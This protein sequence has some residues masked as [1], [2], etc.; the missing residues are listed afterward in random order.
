[1]PRPKK[2]E[3]ILE[4]PLMAGLENES[5]AY[6]SEGGV[7]RK[8]RTRRN[9]SSYIERTN[10]FTNIERGLIPFNY[11]QGISKDTNVDV[12]DAVVLCQKCYWNFALFRNTIDLMTEFSVSDI[13]FTGG[14]KKSKAFFEAFFKKI[15]LWSLQEK[16]FREYY[17]SGNVF[18]YRFDA[19]IQK[20]NIHKLSKTF[21]VKRLASSKSSSLSLPS[22]YIIL[23]PADVQAGGNVSFVSGKYYKLLSDYE[24]ERLRNPRTEEDKE[25]LN[26]LDPEIRKT[27]T[28]GKHH[29]V[30]IPLDP[31]K[32]LAVFYK[33]QDYEPMAIPMGWPVLEA[34][35]AKAEMRKMDMAITRTTHQAILLVT[36]GAKPEEG[37][38]NQK[39]LEAMQKLFAN[40]SVGRVLISD[41]T[42]KAEFIIPEIADLLDPKKYEVLDRDINIG[43]NNILVGGEKYANQQ[44]KVEVFMARLKQAR[45]AFV[46]EFLE[47]EIKRIAKELGLRNYPKAHF[48]DIPLKQDYNM[49]RIYNR[50]IELG[51]LTPEEGIMAIR[52]NRLPDKQSSIESQEEFKK[53]K[54]RGLYEPLIGPASVDDK[55]PA[56]TAPKNELQNGR[57]PQVSTPQPEQRKPGKIGEKQSRAQY[58]LKKIKNNFSLADKLGQKVSQALLKKHGL[59]KLSKEQAEVADQ[60]SELIVA[61]ENPED[62]N[63]IAKIRQYIEKPI[64][65]D[66]ERINKVQDVAL[67]HQINM[68]V[69]GILYASKI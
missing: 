27:I 23:N 12:R 9:A 30:T 47:I 34:I 2:Q 22:R 57:P 4:E 13:Y 35:N 46:N 16:F 8:T 44:T 6:S 58:S 11:S 3:K 18:I 28:D 59:E 32:T 41:Y 24:I 68:Y 53:L 50:L 61:N 14:S 56:K 65:T 42:T 60:I 43:L 37:G 29:A 67:E 55:E 66:R 5:L 17:R 21:G 54:K 62:W 1:M 40:E 45:E 19:K 38:V 69:A 63:K 39:N 10:R 7:E 31:A 20:S 36:M 25:V 15:D 33:K 49:Q 26:S 48:E 51:I 64:D 52:D